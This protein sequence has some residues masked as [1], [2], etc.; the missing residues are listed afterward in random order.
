[1]GT[2]P[3]HLNLFPQVSVDHFQNERGKQVLASQWKNNL[4]NSAFLTCIFS[5]LGQSDEGKKIFESKMNCTDE[6][7]LRKGIYQII[8]LAVL[9]SV[10]R[11]HNL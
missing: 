10:Y 7:Q 3:D 1:M 11:Q 6:S 8:F 2:Y 9:I 5:C 4:I